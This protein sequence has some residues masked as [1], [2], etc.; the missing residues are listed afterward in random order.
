MVIAFLVGGFLFFW[1]VGTMLFKD[2]AM[3]FFLPVGLIALGFVAFF[4]FGVYTIFVG[5]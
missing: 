1:F 5:S 4:L 2:A 3:G